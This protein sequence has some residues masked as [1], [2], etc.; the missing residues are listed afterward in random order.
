MTHVRRSQPGR[1]AVSRMVML[2]EIHVR[3]YAPREHTFGVDGVLLGPVV[4]GPRL[5]EGYGLSRDNET[6]T[7]LCT[8]R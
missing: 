5:Y 4:T 3:D 8:Y 7:L 6:G 1:K 2:G